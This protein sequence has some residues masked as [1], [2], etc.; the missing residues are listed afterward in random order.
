MAQFPNLR[1]WIPPLPETKEADRDMEPGDSP[2]PK[3]ILG[4]TKSTSR[5]E[6]TNLHSPSTRNA[7]IAIVASAWWAGIGSIAYYA[8]LTAYSINP[9]SSRRKFF[10]PMFDWHLGQNLWGDHGAIPFFSVAP[11]V[12]L[13]FAP[14]VVALIVWICARVSLGFIRKAR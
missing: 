1:G 11:Y 8:I 13:I 14:I 10:A 2:S 5:V 12:A 7:R 3:L 4:A 6:T 9:G